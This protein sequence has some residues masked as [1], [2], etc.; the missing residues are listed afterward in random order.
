MRT[1]LEVSSFEAVRFFRLLSRR[2][3][4]TAG[5][6]ISRQTASLAPSAIRVNPVK[7]LIFQSV[8]AGP[9]VG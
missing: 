7:S 3:S 6:R 9:L 2:F 4:P 1:G 5:E 8:F